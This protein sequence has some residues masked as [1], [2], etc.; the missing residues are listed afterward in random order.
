[1]G[2]KSIKKLLGRRAAYKAFDQMS[3][4]RLLDLGLD[5][6]DVKKR[7]VKFA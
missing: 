6:N 3:E 2:I 4:T 5:F 1:M 7:T